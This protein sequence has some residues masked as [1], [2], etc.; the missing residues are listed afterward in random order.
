[1]KAWSEYRKLRNLVTNKKRND[2]YKYQ[3]EKVVENL[4]NPELQLKLI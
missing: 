4:E 1:M 3:K 2:E